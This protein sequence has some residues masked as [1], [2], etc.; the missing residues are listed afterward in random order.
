MAISTKPGGKYDTE[1]GQYVS[2]GSSDAGRNE[3]EKTPINK[4]GMQFFAEKAIKTR[5]NKE[6]IDGIKSIRQVRAYHKY[7]IAHA[8]EFYSTWNEMPP[9][10]QEGRLNTW[11]KEIRNHTQC[12]KDRKEELKKRGIDFEE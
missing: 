12:I 4:I 1:N 3:K 6:I 8:W 5:I 2:D 11:K 9:R 10:E 7:K